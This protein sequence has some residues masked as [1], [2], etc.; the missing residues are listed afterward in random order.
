[1]R[2]AIARALANEPRILLADEPTGALDTR[3]SDD[4]MDIFDQLNASGITLILVTHEADVGARAKRRIIFRDG[5]IV[6]DSK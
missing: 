3:T 2:V 6:E 1:Q 4:V 5:L